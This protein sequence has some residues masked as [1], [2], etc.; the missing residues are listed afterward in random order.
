MTTLDT[1]YEGLTR[2]PEDWQLRTVL[3]DWYE[4]V[5][6]QDVADCLRWMAMHRKRPYRSGSGTYHWFNVE[7]VTTAADPESDI[8]EAVYRRLRGREG[9]ELVFR[10][11]D[12]LKSADEDFYS[13]WREA[14]RHGW[15]EP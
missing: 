13:A 15:A 8:P 2:T 6:Q 11:Y 9:L 1:L 3:A 4:D 14:R 10:D 12:N 7:R 5:G